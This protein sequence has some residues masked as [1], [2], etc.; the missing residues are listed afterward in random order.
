M[1]LWFFFG[2]SI[3]SILKSNLIAPNTYFLVKLY[4]MQV[5]R[6]DKELGENDLRAELHTSK[7]LYSKLLIIRGRKFGPIY[8]KI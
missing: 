4:F 3:V 1:F 8:K 5:F 6:L 7:T 2:H